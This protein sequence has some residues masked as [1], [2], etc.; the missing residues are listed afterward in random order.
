LAASFSN[1]RAIAVPVYTARATG[2]ASS[3]LY[4]LSSGLT[5]FTGIVGER[6]SVMAGSLGI[7]DGSVDAFGLGVA[8]VASRGSEM[9]HLVEHGHS[10]LVPLVP[11]GEAVVAESDVSVRVLTSAAPSSR[12][13]SEGS[14]I[15]A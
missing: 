9:H 7:V 15:V 13:E 8:I 12:N 10:L 2:S 3:I 4:P 5:S 14:G 1:L 11:N 6:S